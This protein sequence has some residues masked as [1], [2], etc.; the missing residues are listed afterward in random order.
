MP[1]VEKTPRPRGLNLLTFIKN[2]SMM[3]MKRYSVK[4]VCDSW[5]SVKQPQTQDVTTDS[6]WH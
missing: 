6:M 5:T 2:V 1:N 4:N 3:N